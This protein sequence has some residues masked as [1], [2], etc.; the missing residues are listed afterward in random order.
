MRNFINT[1]TIVSDD[2]ED[3]TQAPYYVEQLKQIKDTEIYMLD[4][5]C[6]HIFQ[7]DAG[8]YRQIVNYPADVIPIFDL[9][10]T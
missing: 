6:D 3:F 5:D 10:V 4:I 7:Y 8:F 2:V 9:V 1:Y